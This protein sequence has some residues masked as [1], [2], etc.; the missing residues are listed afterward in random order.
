MIVCKRCGAQLED[1][2]KFCTACGERVAAAAPQQA[3][4]A[5]QQAQQ[6]AQQAQQQAQQA[7][8]NFQQPLNRTQQFQQQQQQQQFQQPIVGGQPY[9]QSPVRDESEEKWK[10]WAILGYIF[11]ILFFIPLVADA[12]TSYTKFHSNQQLLLLLGGVAIYLIRKLLGWIPLVRILVGLLAFALGI[13]LLVCVILGI[14]SVVNGTRK[15]LPLIGEI[16]IIK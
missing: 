2:A 16:T 4:Q 10:A 12:K 14:I 8:Q 5:S 6:Q 3:Q 13:F 9:Q 15:P 11:P 1:T 7:Q